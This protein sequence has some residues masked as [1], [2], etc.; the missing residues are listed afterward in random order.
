M[1]IGTGKQLEQ[2]M[3]ETARFE[4]V[5]GKLVEKKDPWSMVAINVYDE[6]YLRGVLA[7]SAIK[8]APIIAEISAGSAKS[9]G[10]GS[11][12]R[13]LNQLG[14]TLEN[15][16]KHPEP[17]VFK[18][19]DGTEY[20]IP[21]DD[22][23]VFLYL[24][25][26]VFGDYLSKNNGNFDKTLIG[27]ENLFKGIAK[28]PL[29]AGGMIDAGAVPLKQNKEVS[30]M[31]VGILKTEG[32]FAEGEYSATAGLGEEASGHE[33]FK[34]TTD[35]NRGEL[36]EKIVEYGREVNPHALAYTAGATHVAMVGQKVQLDWNLISAIQQAQIK[37][38]TYR[39]YPIHGGSSAADNELKEYRG[40]YWKINKATEPKRNSMKAIATYIWDNWQAVMADLSGNL[41]LVG[42]DK[43]A[44][45]D[46][47]HPKNISFPPREAVMLF[48][49]LYS[50]IVGST[51]KV[52]YLKEKVL[53]VK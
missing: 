25:H 23:M 39:G 13:A 11:I 9:L 8:Q 46:A 35:K 20:N 7:A 6:H 30:K 21:L 43:K 44:M 26:F 34:I 5:D 19:M 41:D 14:R 15:I 36:V 27:V 40:V 33:E 52:P 28:V 18:G 12:V 48:A 31:V 3:N 29:L 4:I 51:G 2:V 38:G 22:A 10:D 53:N 45:D 47:H 49:T 32:K 42:G 1:I 24:D 50:D 37:E 17:L 16:M